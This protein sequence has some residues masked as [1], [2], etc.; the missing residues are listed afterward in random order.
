MSEEAFT[1]VE[2]KVKLSDFKM[3]ETYFYELDETQDWVAKILA[4]LE[5]N[6]EDDDEGREK[7][8]LRTQFRVV[9]K[10]SH[11]WGDHL[12]VDGAIQ[13]SYQAAC[14]RCLTITPRDLD[15]EIA[16]GFINDHF[17]KQPEYEESTT[18]YTSNSEYDMYFH[19]KGTANLGELIHEQVF[20]NVDTLPL[21]DPDCK[22]LCSVCGVDR[23]KED[24]GHDA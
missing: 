14:V 13:S 12:L 21:H 3:D 16:G 18:F 17:E 11:P 6:L 19:N 1:S 22:G 8:F 24:C 2:A 4:E 20:M 15:I 7:G 9:R 10:K 23:N 5:E